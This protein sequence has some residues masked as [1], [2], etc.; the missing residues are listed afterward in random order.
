MTPCQQQFMQIH[1]IFAG[2]DKLL[3]IVQQSMAFSPMN[4]KLLPNVCTVKPK[5][6]KFITDHTVL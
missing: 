5:G 6:K 3:D 4:I 1:A 2:P